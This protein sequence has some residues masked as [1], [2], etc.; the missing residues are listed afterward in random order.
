M[1]NKIKALLGF[2]FV[3]IIIFQSVN[4]NNCEMKLVST[5]FP[6]T[7]FE[8]LDKLPFIINLISSLE[9]EIPISSL[10]NAT[11]KNNVSLL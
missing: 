6:I 7:S 10:V 8:K 11:L 2:Y 1:T 3:Y 9:N 5:Y 4:V